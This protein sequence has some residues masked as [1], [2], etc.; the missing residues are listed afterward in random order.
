MKPKPF[1][2]FQCFITPVAMPGTAMPRQWQSQQENTAVLKHLHAH[3]LLPPTRLHHVLRQ[4]APSCGCKL[5]TLKVASVIGDD[6]AKYC[7]RRAD[8]SGT[9][10]SEN[11]SVYLPCLPCLRKPAPVLMGNE[12]LPSSSSVSSTPMMFGFAAMSSA[13]SLPLGMLLSSSYAV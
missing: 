12:Q 7:A 2:Q 3:D 9:T 13:N 5:E 11:V 6:F 1:F 4:L 8:R 10:C